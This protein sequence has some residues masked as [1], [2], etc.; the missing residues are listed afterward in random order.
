SVDALEIHSEQVAG[1]HVNILPPTELV[2][3]VQ[4]RPTGNETVPLVVVAMTDLAADRTGPVFVGETKERDILELLAKE[5][6]GV[7]LPLIA[8]VVV[9]EVVFP[10]LHGAWPRRLR[11]GRRREHGDNDQSHPCRPPETGHENIL[12]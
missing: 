1:L 10:R 7:G 4:P 11:R 6:G 12:S 3:A 2:V 9:E 5:A 8:K